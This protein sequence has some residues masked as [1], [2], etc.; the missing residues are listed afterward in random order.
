MERLQLAAQEL[1][2]IRE[3]EQSDLEMVIDNPVD[4]MGD[5]DSEGGEVSD[6]GSEVEVQHGNCDTERNVDSETEVAGDFELEGVVEDDNEGVRDSALDGTGVDSESSVVGSEM[7]SGD[8]LDGL[9]GNVGSEGDEG[10]L[11][12][13]SGTGDIGHQDNDSR[14]DSEDQDSTGNSSSEDENQ[15]LSNRKPERNRVAPK[16][17]QYDEVGTPTLRR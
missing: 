6:E 12:S 16:R 9:G 7:T 8:E 15:D 11:I 10:E 5:A 3:L 2:K 14:E 1:L 13:D 4:S 17:F